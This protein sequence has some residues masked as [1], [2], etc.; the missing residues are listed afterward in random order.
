M[1]GEWDD[2]DIRVVPELEDN[3]PQNQRLLRNLRAYEVAMIIIR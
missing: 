1:L 3:D 2:D